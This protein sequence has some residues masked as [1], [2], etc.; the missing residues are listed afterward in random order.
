MHRSTAARL[1]IVTLVSCLQVSAG[2]A[3]AAAPAPVRGAAAGPGG[4]TGPG[5][6]RSTGYVLPVDGAAVVL[7]A[8]RPPASR[9]GAGH[10]GVD[11]AL[12]VGGSVR[13][14]GAGTVTHVGPVAGRGTV[15][16]DHPGGL[17]TTYEPVTAV[18]HDGQTVT[19]G[20]RIGTL[21]AGHASCAPAS[22]LHWGAR[23]ADGSYLDPMGLLTG[24]AVRL[25]PWA[26]ARG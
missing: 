24:L 17:R 9:Y 7:T 6:A 5:G 1:L 15:S 22:C 8:F 26:H 4:A 3:T 19:A 11:L 23:L 16:I 14:A 12:A 18:V 13:A 10:R 25:L 2:T 21:Q 20:E